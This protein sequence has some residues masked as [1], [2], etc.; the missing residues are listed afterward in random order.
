MCTSLFSVGEVEAL[1]EV[2]VLDAVSAAAVEVTFAAVLTR[3]RTDGA[4]RGQQVDAF[5]GIA[6]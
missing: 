3:G 2:A 4:G 6:E 5:G 1:V